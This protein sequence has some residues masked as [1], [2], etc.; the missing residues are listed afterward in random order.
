MSQQPPGQ[1]D[2]DSLACMRNK[3]LNPD[4]VKLGSASDY[5]TNIEGD[6]NELS[7]EYPLYYFLYGTLTA[8]ATLQRIT[9]LPEVPKMRKAKLIG[10]AF[11]RWGDYPM[12]IDGKSG[13]EILGYRAD[14][15]AYYETN[16]YREARSLI[17]FADNEEPAKAPGKTFVYAGDVNVL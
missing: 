9:D 6:Q 11:A 16:A 17:Y 2:T 5:L 15:L 10:Y 14:K 7:P 4:E 13:Q 1:E 8:P 3:G 12:L